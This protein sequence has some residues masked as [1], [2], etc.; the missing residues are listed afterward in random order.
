MFMRL[1]FEKGKQ[2]ELIQKEKEL[3]GLSLFQLSKKLGIETSKM[4]GYYF[5]EILLPKEIFEKFSLKKD[6][7]QFVLEE[8]EENWGKSIGGENSFGGGIKEINHPEE[9]EELSEFYGVMLGDGNMTKIRK[10]GT[11][12]YQ[13]RIV[14]DSR[15]DK[16]Y[17]KKLIKPLIEKMFNIKTNLYKVKNKNALFLTAT[18]LRLIEFLESKGFKSGNK[19]KNELCIPPWIK[20]KPKFLRACIRGLYDT[21]GSVY[22]LTNQDSHQISFRNYNLPLMKDVRDSLISMGINCS[23]IT[24]GN[25]ITI[26]KK[27]ELRKFLKEI[28]F[29]NSR[30]LKK[31]RMFNLAL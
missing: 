6:Y 3:F 23:R 28:G 22:K 18:G 26:T 9:S 31:V 24:K 30:H 27:E 5:R 29:H 12:T 10:H 15:H 16:E 21:D 11:G 13:I 8:R 7:D 25:E 19:I 2:K 20:E 14:G 17:L 1:V 4:N